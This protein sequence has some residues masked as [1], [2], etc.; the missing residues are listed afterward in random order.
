MGG[1]INLIGKRYGR[2]I[3]IGRAENDKYGQARW[4]C[5]CDCGNYTIVTGYRLR[6]GNT[7]SCCCYQ[8]ERIIIS[9]T[10]HSMYGTRIYHI[11]ADMIQRCSNKKNP[12]YKNYG[13]KGISV[14]DAWRNDFK[15]FYEW[16]INHGYSDELTIDRIDVNGNYESG[17]CR[18]ANYITQENNKT[19][20]HFIEIN[21]E[22]KTISEW[23]K[24]YNINPSLISNRIFRGWSE[25]NAVTIPAKRNGG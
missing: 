13:A 1:L 18:W 19:T 2:L 6:S 16:S 14:C 25:K 4:K 9:K 7:V 8:T 21:G 10:K 22:N 3:V 5:K 23:S 17:N 24:I 12:K 15:K 20:N 11:W